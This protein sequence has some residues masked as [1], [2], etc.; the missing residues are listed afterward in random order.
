MPMQPKTA[1]VIAFIFGS[2]FITAQTTVLDW[3]KSFNSDID[4][5]G[6]SVT[7][8]ANGNTFTVGTFRGTCDFDPGPGTFNLT[9]TGVQSVFVKKLDPS[10]NLVWVKHFAGNNTTGITSVTL[11]NIGNIYTTG[12][13]QGTVDFDPGPGIYNLTSMSTPSDMFIVKL[14]PAGNFLWAISQ[15]GTNVD[16]ANQVVC[17]NLGHIYITG[18]FTATTDFNPGPGVASLS[19]GGSNHNVFIQKLT[20]D[21]NYVWAKCFPGTLTGVGSDLAYTANHKICISGYF[22]GTVDFDPSPSSFTLTALTAFTG[23][24]VMLDSAGSF[25]WAD[26]LIGSNMSSVTSMC[27]NSS[28]TALI[29]SGA[30]QGTVDFDPGLGTNNITASGNTAAYVIKLNLSGSVQY[31]KTFGGTA[32]NHNVSAQSIGVSPAGHIFIGGWFRNSC[33]FDP[34]LGVYTINT[35]V[36]NNEHI[37]ISRLD[38]LGNFVWAGQFGGA[39]PDGFDDLTVVPGGVFF[40]GY[41][42]DIADFDPSP[43]VYNISAP[44]GIYTHYVAKLDICNTVQSSYSIISCD[45]FT[46]PG[47]DVVFMSGV[48]EDTITTISGCDSL[49]TIQVT[50]SNS[51]TSSVTAVSCDTFV[52]PAGNIYT[53]SGF[54]TET[55]TG[56]NGCDSVVEIDL[57]IP[58]SATIINTVSSCNNYLSP[59][60]NLYS[61][62]GTYF[63][64]LTSS[65]GCDSI[66]QWDVNI[67]GH[68]TSDSLTIIT[69]DSFSTPSG[70]VLY[71]S[72]IYIDT[73]NNTS[74]CDSLIYINLTINESL[75][76]EFF[77]NACDQ[78]VAPSGNIY[79]ASGIYSDT[80]SLFNG[81]DSIYTITLNI[82]QVDTS[83]TATST[84]LSA[85]DS[86]SQYQWVDC[87]NNYMPL[88]GENG[89]TFIPTSNGSYAVI[90][91]K[92]MCSDTSNC[93]LFYDV[94]IS[95]SAPSSLI[96]IYPNPATS[97]VITLNAEF[98]IT[99]I[100]I[101]DLSGRTIEVF[102]VSAGRII[103]LN[104]RLD[105]GTYFLKVFTNQEVVALPLIITK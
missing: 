70:I 57:T 87:N 65:I 90:V 83:I 10:G 56:I 75:T 103:T 24:I 92:N 63:D 15:G 77:V 9:S 18:S 31:V 97:E 60:G 7:A 48:Y 58:Q 64:T 59:Q 53:V 19:P 42:T 2:N 23:F 104:L 98:E 100:E 101:V 72:G 1:A 20:D 33:D 5:Y 34:G 84:T 45:S 69:C 74:G 85:N 89:Q 6:I 14:N 82:T 29:C 4:S 47:G 46:M 21:G 66:L 28:G 52:S 25:Q 11:D 96:T 32:G 73:I 81:C 67:V 8:D 38:S 12:H 44:L 88:A 91:T 79:S 94:G 93:Y 80:V 16:Y 41:F 76:S 49:F 30:F 102:Q 39:Y 43:G 54:Y 22:E 35:P 55:L 37:F 40:T 62:S 61:V 95:E 78:Y 105:S 36:F 27:V 51:S 13:Y 86:S 17:D 50:I 71:S 26:A 99:N 68:T 3:A